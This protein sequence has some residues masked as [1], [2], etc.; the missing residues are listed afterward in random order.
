M[1]A[2]W[3]HILAGDLEKEMRKRSPYKPKHVNPTAHLVALYG[4]CKLNTYDQTTRAADLDMSI[5]AVLRGTA[6]RRD[7]KSI[8]DVC[9]LLEAMNK[10]PKVLKGAEAFNLRIQ[11]LVAQL[12]ARAKAGN[13]AVRA[14][15]AALLWDLCSLWAEVLSVVTHAEYFA[16]ETAV[17]TTVANAVAQRMAGTVLVEA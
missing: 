7:W 6:E 16:A 1:V 8:F 2:T 17:N 4:A 12:H 15:E 14:E 13:K 11:Q 9:N 3:P 5:K 10:M